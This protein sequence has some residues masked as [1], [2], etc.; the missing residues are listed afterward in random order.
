MISS[1][2]DTKFLTVHKDAK[3]PL[4]PTVLSNASHW[5][6]LSIVRE[7]SEECIETAASAVLPQR[8]PCLNYSW[9]AHLWSKLVQKGAKLPFFWKYSWYTC[10]RTV[11]SK[12]R[13]WT[14][15]TSNNSTFALCLNSYN[16]APVH[17]A[18]NQTH[19]THCG[20]L[21]FLLNF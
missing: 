6:C 7:Q 18:W 14:S 2:S 3:I 5:Q 8:V 19:Q 21:N 17:N 16:K 12:C 10:N 13:I 1:S 9:F 20:M 4:H 11:E 15:V